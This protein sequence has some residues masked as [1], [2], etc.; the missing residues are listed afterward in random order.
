[1][2]D[3]Q[4]IK[5]VCDN[6]TRISKLLVD[7]FLIYFIAQKERLEEKIIRQLNSYRKIIA[8]MPKEW[9]G[10]LMSQLIAHRIFKKNGLAEEYLN[11]PWVQM[12]NPKELEYLRFQIE[13]PWRFSYCSI[14]SNVAENFYEM[15]DV[16]SDEIFLLYSPGLADTIRDVGGVP[17]LW[18]LLIG[19]NGECYQTYGTLE[20]FKGIQ[21]FDVFFFAKQLNSKIVFFNEVP[22]LIES[23]PMPFLMVWSGAELPA[24]FYKKEMVVFNKSEYYVKDFSFEKYE[25]DFIIEK[26]YPRYMLS[27]KRWHTFPHFA[28]CFYHAKK[29]RFLIISMTKRGYDAL[30]SALNKRD[31]NFP[32]NPEI[33]AT[34]A[35]LFVVKD[36]LNIDVE[37]NPYEKHFQKETSP[38]NQ[39]ELDKINL[40]LKN[41]IPKLNNKLDYDISEMASSAGI[42][43]SVAEQIAE[44]LIKKI[45]NNPGKR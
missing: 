2:I 14:Q 6:N 5:T 40:F 23:N 9:V 15:K 13:H 7:E 44:S 32:I 19:F 45:S 11:H 28:K 35:M 39:K 41:L 12:R 10:I 3:Y 4:K 21:P 34:P 22:D 30:I 1:M 42:D 25:E 43:L 36:V 24:T 27:L 38:Q 18:F 33:L 8:K 29:N 16:L 17:Q 37:I 26:K 31:N 20:Y